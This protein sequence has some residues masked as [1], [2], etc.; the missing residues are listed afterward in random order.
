[1]LITNN[2]IYRSAKYLMIF[3]CLKWVDRMQVKLETI[4][5]KMKKI[6]ENIFEQN[7][8]SIVPIEYE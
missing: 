8:G 3:F 1:M 4:K 5:W 2:C 6:I 7:C